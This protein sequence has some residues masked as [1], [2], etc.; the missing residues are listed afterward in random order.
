MDQNIQNDFLS[1]AAQEERLALAILNKVDSD[2]ES[3]DETVQRFGFQNLN[4]TRSEGVEGRD[5]TE[6]F[7]FQ[8]IGATQ[9]ASDLNVTASQAAQNAR[10]AKG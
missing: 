8:N 1:N 7:G 9:H 10:S 2:T 6:Q 3:V 4:A 5:T